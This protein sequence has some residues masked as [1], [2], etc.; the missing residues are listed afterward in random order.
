MKAKFIIFFI[1]AI[2]ITFFSC[3]KSNNELL[4]EANSDPTL[5]L[6]AQ[7]VNNYHLSN[8]QINKLSIPSIGWSF[9]CKFKNTEKLAHIYLVING[10]SVECL[11]KTQLSFIQK[12]T[13]GGLTINCKV[14]YHFKYVYYT[15]RV[16]VTEANQLHFN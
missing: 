14:F 12:C 10:N 9:N 15:G 1:G 5:N 8:L 16:I 3:S 7:T 2:S 13:V 6:T 11:D 4:N